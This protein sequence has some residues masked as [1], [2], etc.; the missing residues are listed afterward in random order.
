MKK[1]IKFET[2]MLAK[3]KGFKM[4]LNSDN[5]YYSNEGVIHHYDWF[6]PEELA[7]YIDAVTQSE[8]QSWLWEYHN[9][10]VSS[11]PIFSSNE[12]LGV[13]VFV[14]SWAL[15]TIVNVDYYGFDIY[16]G[17]EKGLEEALKLL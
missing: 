8:I 3:A 9:L 1:Y 15:P 2:A 14:N 17:L 11:V 7:D 5:W 10:W 16:D 12:L 13:E 6:R 4:P